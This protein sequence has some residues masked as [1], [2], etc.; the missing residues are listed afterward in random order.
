MDN[1][2]A[3]NYAAF[4][5]SL[6]QRGTVVE[7]CAVGSREQ[8]GL[9]Y[10]RGRYADYEARVVAGNG[11]VW[12]GQGEE[13]RAHFPPQAG[14][15][16][17][18]LVSENSCS[19]ALRLSYGNFSYFTGGD[20]NCDTNYGRD[21]W[22]DIETPAAKAAGAVSVATCS[23]HGYFDATGPDYVTALQP[24]VWIIQSWHASHPAI[25]V[26][27]NLYSPVLYP[28]ERE[29]FC[30]GL[31]PAAGLV[32]GRFSDHLRSSQGHV[33][34]RVSPGGGEFRV[35]VLDDSDEGDGVKAILGP[36]A[37]ST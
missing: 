2:T 21:A 7:R 35:L 32:C 24:R 4:A 3:K 25:S 11:E 20:L 17:S 6:A 5:Q 23:H 13:K 37:S 30:L 16:R 14:V 27:A 15:P 18:E 26:L 22:R 36:Y 29:V 1:A 33:L 12:T 8:I 34:V 28:G 31:H 19:I 10:D 9:K